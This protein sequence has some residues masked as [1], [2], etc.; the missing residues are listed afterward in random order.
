MVNGG[1]VDLRSRLITIA[2]LD[3]QAHLLGSALKDGLHSAVLRVAGP[4]A[5][6]KILCLAPQRILEACI[7]YE[8]I[9]DEDVG[10]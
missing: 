3:H 8:A 4:T 7:I 5:Q 6:A 9:R 1:A 10:S 2:P